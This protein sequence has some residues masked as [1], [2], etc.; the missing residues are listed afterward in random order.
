MT[1][2]TVQY[3]KDT[4]PKTRES[5]SSQPLHQTIETKERVVLGQIKKRKPLIESARVEETK[6][7]V[8]APN[9][10]M[11]SPPQDSAKISSI[12]RLKS[13]DKLEPHGMFKV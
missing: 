1:G 12:I 3:E 13:R 9:A 2:E 6:Y 7:Y 4:T 11:S 5:T 10:G 8:I